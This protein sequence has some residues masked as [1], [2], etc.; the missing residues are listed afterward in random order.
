MTD[1]NNFKMPFIKSPEFAANK[2]YKGLIKTNSFEI[3]FP[4]E[5]TTILKF[6]RILPYW[7]YFYLI[8]KLT[9]YQKR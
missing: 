8:E 3:T 6:F 7:K 4:K 5:L 1:K 9:K 2:I